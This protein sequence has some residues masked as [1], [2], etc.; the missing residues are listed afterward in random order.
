MDKDA[1]RALLK[2]R[3][4]LIRPADHGL[5]RH[6]PRGRRAPGHGLTQDQIDHLLHRANGTYSDLE[7][8]RLKKPQP[9]L[10]EAVA[11]LLRFNEHE[12]CALW[13]YAAACDPPYPLHPASGRKVPAVWQEAV[14]G[15]AH[16][17]Y[18][19]DQS[20][21]V[22]AQNA[23]WAEMFPGGEPPQNTMRWMLLDERARNEVLTDWETR[24]APYVM[25]QLRTACAALPDDPILREIER[26][27]LADPIAGPIY[28]TAP[29]R[30]LD[31]DGDE[32]PLLHAKRG[33]GWVTVCASV[34]IG[35]PGARSIILV[36]GK[37]P[38]IPQITT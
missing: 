13:R 30:F 6:S 9:D 23:A 17:A 26:D 35:S 31:L 15:I 1:L 14:D 5:L 34:P 8:G 32:R 20:W 4:A 21:E 27:V 10:L 18:V 16:M 36:F 19:N 25:P 2:R 28:R 29:D 11:R 22:L 38:R 24:W 33:P 12:W 37:E 3:R 7:G